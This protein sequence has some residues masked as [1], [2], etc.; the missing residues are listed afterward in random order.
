MSGGLVLA[1]LSA[2]FCIAL[3]MLFVSFRLKFIIKI[4]S[5]AENFHILFQYLI[6]ITVSNRFPAF[7]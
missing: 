3:D 5:S 1:L 7:L 4:R 6:S 2:F